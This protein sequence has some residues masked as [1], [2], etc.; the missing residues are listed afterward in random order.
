VPVARASEKQ[1]M[2]VDHDCANTPDATHDS[3]DPRTQRHLAKDQ[4]DSASHERERCHENDYPPR[5][6]DSKTRELPIGEILER[7]WQDHQSKHDGGQDKRCSHLALYDQRLNQR[8]RR[9]E[10]KSSLSARSATDG[11][12]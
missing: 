8:E 3:E 6:R 1:I 11:A 2:S 4:D 12:R 10:P 5:L 7:V 9:L